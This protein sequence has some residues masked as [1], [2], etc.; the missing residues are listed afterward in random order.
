[1][2]LLH[3]TEP[4]PTPLPPL[5][6]PDLESIQ[7]FLAAAQG[8]G[9]D[10]APCLDW[11][12]HV[13]LNSLM[14]D[15]ASRMFLPKTETSPFHVEDLF[16]FSAV[17]P[18]GR[19]VVELAHS[20]VVAPIWN[21]AEALSAMEE[22]RGGKPLQ[23]AHGQAAGWYIQEL[24]LAVIGGQVHR[25]YF[26]RFYGQGSALLNLYHLKSLAEHVSTDG[27]N[28]YV[29]EQDGS[30]T[31]CPVLVPRMAVLYELALKRHF[32]R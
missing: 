31:W 25:A 30:E 7:K 11:A 19:Q 32:D 21:N 17:K 16:P 22:V 8:A 9:L 28:W 2:S 3:K 15:S 5:D 10:P 1:M 26:S 24:N 14:A 18:A 13:L 4:T 20:F 23:A 27:E 29:K 6:C 12:I